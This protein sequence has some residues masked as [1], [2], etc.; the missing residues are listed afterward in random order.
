MNWKLQ[1]G[2][3]ISRK[4]KNEKIYKERDPK[5]TVNK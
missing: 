1:K 4:N 5:S 2:K 3:Y